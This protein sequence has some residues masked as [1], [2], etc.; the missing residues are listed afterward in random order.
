MFG[1]EGHWY[2]VLEP[3][4]TIGQVC[5]P[6]SSPMD[7]TYVY[8]VFPRKTW[9][10][11]SCFIT[12]YLD[13]LFSRMEEMKQM[14]LVTF[15]AKGL[16]FPSVH[17]KTGAG[18]ESIQP[19][20]FPESLSI[21]LGN[22]NFE[23]LGVLEM[24]PHWWLKRL[25][26]STGRETSLDSAGPWEQRRQ[27]FYLKFW[28]TPSPSSGSRASVLARKLTIQ[29][30]RVELPEIFDCQLIDEVISLCAHLLYIY[31]EGIFIGF[32]EW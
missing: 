8:W 28:P 29:H 11:S 9:W 25:A 6:R 10:W 16:C 30:L 1:S 18:R 19:S 7:P 31:W 4:F 22:G 12:W 32:M 24:I 3:G 17:R 2:Y 13:A 21:C 5:G 20:V 14:L 27:G 15:S 26:S 23:P